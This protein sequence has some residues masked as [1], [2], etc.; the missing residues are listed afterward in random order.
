MVLGYEDGDNG[1]I[2]LIERL[3]EKYPQHKIH[4]IYPSDAGLEAVKDGESA[5]TMMNSYIAREGLSGTVFLTVLPKVTNRVNLVRRGVDLLDHS[6]FITQDCVKG[7]EKLSETK[8]K[9]EEKTGFLS[10]KE[11]ARNGCQHAGD[12]WCYVAAA[13]DNGYITPFA[14][15]AGLVPK[16]E[17]LVQIDRDDLTYEE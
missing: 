14:K 13:M 2:E 4:L 11:F 5:E 10:P 6:Q 15:A 16:N 9:K 12:A 8:M 1:Q 3:A 17:N 7:I